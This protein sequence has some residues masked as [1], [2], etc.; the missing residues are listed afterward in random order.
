M[1]HPD[2]WST[3]LRDA[4]RADVLYDKQPS[5][6][7]AAMQQPQDQRYIGSESGTPF[8]SGRFKIRMRINDPIFLVIFVAQ[9]QY[10]IALCDFVGLLS[11]A[12][13]A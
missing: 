11:H 4:P 10:L 8:D 5:P 1:S 6:G 2:Q 13:G 7:A 3:Q 12:A 9:V